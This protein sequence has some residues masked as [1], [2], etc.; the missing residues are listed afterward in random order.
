[1]QGLQVWDE[2]GNLIS[3]PSFSWGRV[4]DVIDIP[5]STSGSASYSNPG[6]AYGARWALLQPTSTSFSFLDP[7]P[8]VGVSYSISGGTITYSNTNAY[9]FKLILGVF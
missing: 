1:M 2:D 6:S 9:A 4:T 7:S 8:N 5:A 3:D